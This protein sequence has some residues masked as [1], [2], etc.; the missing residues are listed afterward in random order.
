MESEERW[1]ADRICRE[2]D[3][4]MSRFNLDCFDS[5][6]LC[7]SFMR[8]HDR[9]RRELGPLLCDSGA[10]RMEGM[11]RERLPVE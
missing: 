6:R 3:I 11:L 7:D 5:P 8:R 10:N 9:S 1:K 4:S 2:Q